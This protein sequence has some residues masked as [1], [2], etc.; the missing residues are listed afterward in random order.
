[1]NEFKLKKVE[2]QQHKHNLKIRKKIYT[3][4]VIAN[5]NYRQK[6]SR[7]KRNWANN[8]LA[9]TNSSTFSSCSVIQTQI[10]KALICQNLQHTVT[11][12][13]HTWSLCMVVLY[14]QWE[15]SKPFPNQG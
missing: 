9:K 12:Y 13:T 5:L 11:Q 1:L 10:T 15:S 7:D 14:C 4:A 3:I 6:K 8:H 2:A